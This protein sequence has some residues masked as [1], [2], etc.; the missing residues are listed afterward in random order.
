[1]EA[2]SR[3]GVT[4]TSPAPP[5]IPHHRTRAYHTVEFGSALEVGP[6]A[7]GGSAQPFTAS[8]A[9]PGPM[10]AVPGAP[11]ETRRLPPKARG[12]RQRMREK[13]SGVLSFYTILRLF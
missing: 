7:G 1:M 5:I 13:G 8:P 9:R 11:W 6:L 3:A 12:P 10:A 4:M 2:R